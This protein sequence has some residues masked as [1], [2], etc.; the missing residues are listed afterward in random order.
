MCR[1]SQFLLAAG[2]CLLAIQSAQA[3]PIQVYSLGDHGRGSLGP[4]Y[5]LRLD[6][7][8]VA[9]TFSFSPGA[10]LYWDTTADSA[11]IVGQLKQNGPDHKPTPGGK[12]W[13]VNYTLDG[14][15]AVSP[16]GFEALSGSGSLTHGSEVFDLIGKAD[17]SGAVFKFAADGHRLPG[18]GSSFVGRGWVQGDRGANDFLFQAIRLPDPITEESVPEPATLTV[19]GLGLAG[20]AGMRMRRRR[21]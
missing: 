8:D 9:A 15:S 11:K 1:P 10:R 6:D 19:L 16:D 7:R 4:H 14:I 20:L 12:V 18:D 17:R 13:D 3:G 5:G 21:R 2:S